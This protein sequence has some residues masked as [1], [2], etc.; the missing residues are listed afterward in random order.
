HV[1]V[2][3]VFERQPRR[4][5]AAQ[6]A[7]VQKHQQAVLAMTQLGDGGLQMGPQ[8]S[9]LVHRAASLG[10]AAIT[11]S[12]LAA[13]SAQASSRA[14]ASWSSAPLLPGA[15][16]GSTHGVTA[17]QPV[18]IS[19]G[20]GEGGALAQPASSIRQRLASPVA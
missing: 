16:A 18:T 15:V 13:H 7:V 5:G 3:L 12:T 9:G 10:C 19:V 11:A 20:A 14:S 6:R 4:G 8:R 1:E 2:V 17:G